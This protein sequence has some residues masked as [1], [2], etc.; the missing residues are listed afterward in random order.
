MNN[1]EL[2]KRKSARLKNYD[3][4]SEGAYFITICTHNR[5][6]IFSSIAI[7]DERSI[8][9]STLQK[10]SIIS[11]AVGYL[12]MNVSRDLHKNGYIGD[13]W[14]RSFHDHI[15]RGEEDYLK[16]WNYIDTNSQKWE[17]DCF[18]NA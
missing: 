7:I 3:Y 14:Q 9:E 6:E 1:I 17:N 2:P 16:I 12:K 11:N 13:I 18:Y 5:K 10:R 4:S 15:I 8:R